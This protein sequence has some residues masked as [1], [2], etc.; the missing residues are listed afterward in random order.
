METTSLY[1]V[2]IA[3]A[4]KRQFESGFAVLEAIT[5]GSRKLQEAQ[6]KAATEAHAAVEA[7]H[8]RV[9]EAGDGQELWRLQSEWMSASLEKSLAY[10][11]E[12]Y[13]ATIETESNVAKLLAAQLPL[14]VT[15]VPGAGGGTG[16][17]L[18]EMMNNTF[19]RWME[20][21]RQFYHAPGFSTP[22]TWQQRDKAG[23]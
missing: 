15:L 10:W 9:A 13:Q 20:A 12:L 18:V 4:L 14:A 19:S 3:P 23:A 16:G 5:E 8:K 1:D 17:P 11:R 7:I 22:Q 2:A 21:T 6:L